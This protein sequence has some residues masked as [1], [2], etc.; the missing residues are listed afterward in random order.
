MLETEE[1]KHIALLARIGLEDQEIPRYQRDLSTVLDWMGEL[2]SVKTESVLPIGHITGME[3]EAMKDVVLPA[4]P[5]ERDRI[6]KNFPETKDGY[7]KVR[8][9]F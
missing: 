8:S 1:V 5:A 6:V 4:I 2:K 9:V 7:N 3:N